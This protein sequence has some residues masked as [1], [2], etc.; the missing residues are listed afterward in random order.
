MAAVF[1]LVGALV[2]GTAVAAT[3]GKGFVKPDVISLSVVAAAMLTIVLWTVVAWRL[4]LPTS[5]SHELVAGLTGAG[6]AAAGPS[7]LLWGGWEK[8]LIGLALSTFGVFP[9]Y[10]VHGSSLLDTPAQ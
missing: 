4:G 5:K 9:G 1:N 2:T 8:V 3:I 10:S 6:L 7:V